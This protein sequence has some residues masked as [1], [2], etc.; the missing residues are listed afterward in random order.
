MPAEAAVAAVAA[1]A[2]PAGTRVVLARFDTVALAHR[3]QPPPAIVRPC[4]VCVLCVCPGARSIVCFSPTQ[5]HIA[6][7]QI[8]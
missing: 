5:K 4:V 3:S 8:D 1:A 7:I 6:L 2:M